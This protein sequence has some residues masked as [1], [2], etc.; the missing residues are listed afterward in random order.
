MLPSLDLFDMLHPQPLVY[1]LLHSLWIGLM[2]AGML[3]LALRWMPAPWAAGRY[4]VA[5]L[6]QVVVLLAVVVVAVCLSLPTTQPQREAAPRNLAVTSD[7]AAGWPLGAAQVGTIPTLTEVNASDSS[8]V[9]VWLAWTDTLAW[10]YLAGV[11]LMLLRMAWA[12]ADAGRLV[13]QG[14]PA[15]EQTSNLVDRLRR[16]LG[17]GR[18]VR[19][20]VSQVCDSPAVAGVLWPTLVLPVS[21]LTELSPEAIRAILLHELAHIRRHDYLLN[22]GQ[23]LIEA[24]LFF[25]PAVWWI[26]RQIRIER[27]ACCDGLAVKH[28]GEPVVYSQA[29]ADWAD[30]RQAA[31][32]ESSTTRKAMADQK[33]PTAAM[34]IG[35]H[36]RHTLLGRLRRVLLPGE[37]PE[38]HISP[39]SLLMLLVLAGLGMALVWQGTTVAVVVAAEIVSPAERVKRVAEQVEEHAPPRPSPGDAPVTFSGK[40][41]T[42]DGKPLPEPLRATR[43][44]R[45][46]NSSELSALGE[47][48]PQFKFTSQPGV[49]MLIVHGEG[50]APG[51]SGPFDGRSGAEFDEIEIVLPKGFPVDFN[52]RDEEGKPVPGV[53]V[54]AGYIIN[55][56]STNSHQAE[57]DPQGEGVIPHALAGE[58]FISAKAPGFQDTGVTRT[59]VEQ[60]KTLEIVVRKAQP[61]TG[62]VVSA[63]GV[64]IGGAVLQKFVTIRQSDGGN[65]IHGPNG[66]KLA[67]TDDEGRFTLDQL[68]SDTVYHLLVSHPEHGKRVHEGVRPGQQGLKMVLGPDFTLT[69][70]LEGDLSKLPQRRGETY[71]RYR[72]GVRVGPEGTSGWDGGEAMI[73]R[74]ETGG[75]FTLKGLLPAETTITAGEHKATIDL[76]EPRSQV[77][78]DLNDTVPVIQTRQVELTFEADKSALPRGSVRVYSPGFRNGEL[79]DLPI[80]DGRVELEVTVGA[81]LYVRPK[82][83]IGYW[84]KERHFPVE[85]GD[86][87]H[88]VR[89]ET[90]PAG[91]ISGQALLASGKPD[92]EI[93]VSIRAI[94]KPEEFKLQT[95]THS[96]SQRVD[97]Q[98]GFVFTPLP[99]GAKYVVIAGKGHNK[100]VSDPVE[101]TETEPTGDVQLSLSPDA[102][103]SGTVVGPSGKPL[104]DIPLQLELTH[105]LAST[106]WGPGFTTDRNGRFQFDGLSSTLDGYEI[107]LATNKDYQPQ[108]IPLNPGGPPVTMK[109]ENGHVLECAVLDAETGRPIPGVELYAYP[110]N[111]QADEPYAYEA[112]GKTV[113][114]GTT[115]FSNLAGRE[116]Q[117]NDRNGLTWDKE[118]G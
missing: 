43:H 91:A 109:L 13:R 30:R 9:G 99:L 77:T 71:I 114:D 39:V 50:Y 79:S 67:T 15:D 62:Q 94:D 19:V 32:T 81:D 11:T 52:V 42:E 47:I 95:I 12:V 60:G 34:G 48:G 96:S 46:E 98:G 72:Q 97:S 115:R 17:I 14:T 69:G 3:A 28:M 107:S 105:S 54:S 55:G 75:K 58:Y 49:T 63:D 106:S 118:K 37:Q 4:A 7:L 83:I 68:V 16:D 84:F 44:T 40:V 22:L 24:V 5:M 31:A 45:F 26:S 70:T 86:Q 113:A 51:V 1:A 74:T 112:E 76:T 64:P 78:I 18:R 89:L 93:Q 102:S 25:N 92:T 66:D 101:L 23:M 53:A 100:T 65:H 111:R 33:T 90:F 104:A 82:G 27:E 117:I 21:L 36:R 56:G 29:L 61:V 85:A 2:V 10:F 103:A 73:E 6:A 8:K 116:F 38:V 110:L 20:V 87:P 80:V 108:S 35:V 57:S 88:T 59:K 41:R